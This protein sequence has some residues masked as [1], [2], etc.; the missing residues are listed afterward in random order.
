MRRSNR[1]YQKKDER[2]HKSNTGS[3][4]LSLAYD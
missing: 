3:N 4:D 1:K 2:R